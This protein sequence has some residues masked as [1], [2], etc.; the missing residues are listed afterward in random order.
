MTAALLLPAGLAALAALLLPLLIHLARRTEV[1]PIDF[2]ALRWLQQQPRPRQRIRF[3]EWFLL[4]VRLLL[5][6]LLA[7][8]L[9]QPVL[10]GSADMT[11]WV[12]VVPGADVRAARAVAGAR[13]VWLAPGFPALEQDDLPIRAAASVSSLLRELDADMPPGVALTV[14]VPAVIAGDGER[15]RLS[16]RVNWRIVGGVMPEAAARAPMALTVVGDGGGLR[17]MR[18]A[19]MAWAPPGRPA[20]FAVADP[21]ASLPPL[22]RRL[23]WLAPGP[24]PAAVRDWVRRGGTLLLG[25]G[26]V[27]DARMTPVWRDS[28]GAP[29]IEGATDGQG[30]VLRF[31]RVLAPAA[32][33]DL[34]DGDFPLRLAALLGSRTEPARVAAA[35]HAPLPGGP[36]PAD[37][38][39]DL[40]PWLALLIAALLLG[41]RW[42]ATARRRALAA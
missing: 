17:Y 27:A 10:R 30:R 26:I 38:A 4:A 31:A 37:A 9:A 13:A 20:N 36:T 5:L 1:A 11:P 40:R 29:I 7:L 23:V 16:R 33:P 28:V 22:D 2:A 39:R 19:A 3:D 6:A 24:L 25:A 35:D 32:M 8:W 18:A 21:A 41:E 12:A 42:L 14:F 15:P 34:L